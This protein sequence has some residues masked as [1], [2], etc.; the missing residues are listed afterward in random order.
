MRNFLDSIHLTLYGAIVCFPQGWQIGGVEAE[1]LRT[2]YDDE[3][4]KLYSRPRK[5]VT[6]PLRVEWA[7]GSYVG[8]APVANLTKLMK[9]FGEWAKEEAERDWQI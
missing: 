3:D 8:R 7:T 6:V 9:L 5:A 2:L 4:R 1:K